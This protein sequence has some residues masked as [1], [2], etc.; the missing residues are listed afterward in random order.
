M[1][2]GLHITVIRHH[3]IHR[4]D[5]MHLDSVDDVLQGLL[6]LLWNRS[7]W[8]VLLIKQVLLLSHISYLE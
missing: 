6:G 4:L 3:P 7:S 8:S 5:N 2:R 1:D